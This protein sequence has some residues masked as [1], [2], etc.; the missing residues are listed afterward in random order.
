MLIYS[1]YVNIPWDASLGDKNLPSGQY[2]VVVQDPDG[3]CNAGFYP[4]QE[5]S[6]D[7]RTKP[8]TTIRSA[9]L[10]DEAMIPEATVHVLRSSAADLLVV[11]FETP[12]QKVKKTRTIMIP[13]RRK[14]RLN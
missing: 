4:A 11:L 9:C 13:L 1:F 7:Q 3:S 10:L 8:L 6:R 14:F 5:F 2:V 12:D